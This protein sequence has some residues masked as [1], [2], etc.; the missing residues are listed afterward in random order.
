M[1][2]FK[3][4]PKSYESDILTTRVVSS[5]YC[6]RHKERRQ[7]QMYPTKKQQHNYN[8]THSQKDNVVYSTWYKFV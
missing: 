4:Q 5:S 3:L 6:S 7:Q 2:R 1:V 8:S